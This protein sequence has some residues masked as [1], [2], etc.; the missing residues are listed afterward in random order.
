MVLKS[1]SPKMTLKCDIPY[2]IKF[3]E[4]VIMKV[5]LKKTLCEFKLGIGEVIDSLSLK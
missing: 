3:Y 1:G 2:S 4:I 5:K